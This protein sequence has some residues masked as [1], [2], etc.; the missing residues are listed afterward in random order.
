ML[1]IMDDGYARD[2]FTREV[3]ACM[4]TLNFDKEADFVRLIRNALIDAM[5]SPGLPPET[6]CR[7]LLDMVR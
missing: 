2:L 7:Y 6:R 3:E 1:D 5:D 4:R